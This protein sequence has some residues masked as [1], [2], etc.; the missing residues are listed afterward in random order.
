MAFPRAFHNLV[1]LPDGDVLAVGGELS[2]DGWDSS[3]SVLAGE[4]WSPASETW[5]TVAW[6]QRGR[7]YQSTA[8]LLPD[9]RVLVAGS[10]SDYGPGFDDTTAEIY[11][12]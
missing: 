7:L 11:S 10:G 6:M 8:L 2:R 3:Q 12:P 1:L 9:A 5:R 4:I